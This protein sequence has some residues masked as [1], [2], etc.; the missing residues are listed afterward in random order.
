MSLTFDEAIAVRPTS[1]A[2]T[3]DAELWH[4]W[5]SLAG[6]HGGYACAVAVRAMQASLDE[7]PRRLRTL[8]ASFLRGTQPGPATVIVETLRTGRRL[9]VRRAELWQDD[10]LRV[11]VQGTF[12]GPMQ[13]V[14]IDRASLPRPEPA[15]RLPFETDGLVEHFERFH[16]DL[17]RRWWPG[18]DGELARLSGWIRLKEERA[19]DDA[20]VV[21]VADVLPPTTF[22]A[23]AV[24]QGGM[25]LDL[26]VTLLADPGEADAAAGGT[27][28][29]T[30]T[31][32][33]EHAAEGLA[34]ERGVLWAGEAVLATVSQTRY[35]GRA[36]TVLSARRLD[37]AGA[38]SEPPG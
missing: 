8:T 2:N 33:T 38:A 17:D 26:A 4:G 16:C 22:A 31:V 14:A 28:E 15:N 27:G 30:M 32:E 12:A 29:V 13:G 5:S 10:T 24:P 37:E 3:F 11:T 19:L 9:A 36:P 25:T 7:A 20:L 21:L 18:G 23:S 35:V 34:W 6:M 1:E